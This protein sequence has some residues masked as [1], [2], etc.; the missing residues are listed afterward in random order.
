MIGSTVVMKA[1]PGRG[2]SHIQ[3]GDGR[4]VQPGQDGRVR[5]PISAIAALQSAGYQIVDEAPVGE[6][7]TQI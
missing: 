3:L 2:S 4:V 7:G 6:T 5:V 1:A